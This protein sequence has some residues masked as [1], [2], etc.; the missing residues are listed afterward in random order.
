MLMSV[1]L[2]CMSRSMGQTARHLTQGEGG[3]GGGVV[4]GGGGKGVYFIA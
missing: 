2:A 1:S 4:V 3:E